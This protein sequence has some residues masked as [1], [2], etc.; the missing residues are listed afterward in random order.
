LRFLRKRPPVFSKKLSVDNVKLITISQYRPEQLQE[1]VMEAD[2]RET[3]TGVNKFQ[4]RDYFRSNHVLAGLIMT[5][6]FLLMIPLS[7][8]IVHFYSKKEKT[9]VINMKYVSSPTEYERMESNEKH[10][11]SKTPVVKKRSPVKLE[12]VSAKTG[13]KLFEKEY[14]PRGLRQDIAMYIFSELKIDEDAV[15]IYLSETA[16]TDKKQSLENV[17][18]VKG[19][20]TFIILKDG[21]LAK[22]TLQP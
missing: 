3:G 19:D 20:G 8:T 6:F 21:K 4:Y 1:L 10:M 13:E 12:V 22:A 2:K 9:L 15:N 14:S 18:L 5:A 16:F 17:S 11:Q 7:N